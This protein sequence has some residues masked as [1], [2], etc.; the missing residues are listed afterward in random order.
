VESLQTYQD[1]VTAANNA[2][3]SAQSLH[4]P[5]GVHIFADFEPAATPTQAFFQGYFDTFEQ[6]IYHAGFYFDTTLAQFN[7]PFCG[8]Y[9]SDA[10]LP[11][12]AYIYTYR[13]Q[14]TTCNFTYRT[15]NPAVPPCNPP[16]LIYQYKIN[17]VVDQRDRKNGRVDLDL[18][19]PV[20]ITSLW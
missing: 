12:V 10:K 14:Q 19:M 5:A 15:F 18:A 17:C 9:G 6:S 4:V 16:T 20:G 13:P 11:N 2:I 1:G 7:T 3:S 8:A